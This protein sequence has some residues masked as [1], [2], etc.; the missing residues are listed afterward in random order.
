MISLLKI[1]DSLPFVEIKLEFKGREKLLKNVLVDTGSAGTILKIDSVESIGIR[2]EDEDV[3]GTVS[4]V[5][6][7]EFVYIKTV[8]S[9]EL[10]GL[11]IE[12]FK[13]DIGEMDYG[14]NFDGII[15]MDFLTKI[16][17]IIDLQNMKMSSDEN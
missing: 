4:G 7:T 9:L 14:Y 15:G 1:I 13:V 2:A 16:K 8:D 11:K 12:N 6:G 17:S 3:I 5:G 10:C